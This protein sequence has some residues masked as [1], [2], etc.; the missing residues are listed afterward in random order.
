MTSQERT[1]IPEEFLAELEQFNRKLEQVTG[2]Q[3]QLTVHEYGSCSNTGL[4]VCPFENR[5]KYIVHDMK[6]ECKDLEGEYSSVAQVKSKIKELQFKGVEMVD[7][8]CWKCP[9][10]GQY[11]KQMNENYFGKNSIHNSLCQNCHYCHRNIWEIA[12]IDVLSGHIYTSGGGS[13]SI[14]KTIG[15]IRFE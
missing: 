4:V 5:S 15:L 8:N 2:K 14:C 10:C 9:K 6:N 12:M 11:G 13:I 1:T 3:Y 7:Q